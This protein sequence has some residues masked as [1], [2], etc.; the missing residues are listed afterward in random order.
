M[1][2]MFDD[3]FCS[4]GISAEFLLLSSAQSCVLWVAD[5]NDTVQAEPR[6]WRAESAEPHLSSEV[7]AIANLVVATLWLRQWRSRERSLT[8]GTHTA[9]GTDSLAQGHSSTRRS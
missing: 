4:P 6:V 7:S 5:I 3:E 9:S 2:P 1:N 8:Q